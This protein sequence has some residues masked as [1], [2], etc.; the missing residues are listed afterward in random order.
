VALCKARGSIDALIGRYMWPTGAFAFLQRDDVRSLP[1]QVSGL[2]W[3]CRRPAEH[4]RPIAVRAILFL[5]LVLV[6]P[7]HVAAN[8]IDSA[9]QPGLYDD[10]DTDQLVTQTLSPDAMIGLAVLVLVCL[11]S[12]TS[13]VDE[14]E[15]EHDVR[16]R[17]EP[18]PRAPPGP[19]AGIESWS[20]KAYSVTSPFCRLPI[21]SAGNVFRRSWSMALI[22]HD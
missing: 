11:V 17:R 14:A 18:V 4:S 8:P 12:R 6:V 1:A 20:S 22:P 16:S 5:I 10:A 3:S 13:P 19:I 21:V 15:S 9:R 7:I 2:A